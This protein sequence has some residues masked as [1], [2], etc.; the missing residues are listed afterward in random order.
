MIYLVED[1]DY[2]KIGY[3][4]DVNKRFKQYKTY[5]LYPQLISY[6]IGSTEDEKKLHKLCEQ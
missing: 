5:S 6:K 2:L 4:E 3:A 1:R